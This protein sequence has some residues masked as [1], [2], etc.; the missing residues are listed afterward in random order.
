MKNNQDKTIYAGI[1]TGL[2]SQS[3]TWPLEYIKMKR[4]INSKPIMENLKYEY[5]RYGLKGYTRGLGWHLGG[6]I[7][8]VTLRFFTYDYLLNNGID[9]KLFAGFISG[10]MEASIIYT[11]SEYMKIQAMKNNKMKDIGPKIKSNPKV[12]FQ[13]LLPTIMRTA[14][15]Q[16]VTFTFFDMFND[17]FVNNMGHTVGKLT[18]GS[19]GAIT[20]VILNNPIDVIKTRMQAENKNILQT[21]KNIIKNYGI[22]GF[23]KGGLIRSC[24]MAPL[25]ALN[26]YIFDYFKNN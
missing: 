1:M 20:A 9:N 7:P 18:T 19:L 11:P 4:Q 2:F 24:R 14:S 10:I 3:L 12:L 15:N 13:G 8:R 21:S 22:T 25:Y 23:W 16:A 17:Y 5:N 26:F 6:G